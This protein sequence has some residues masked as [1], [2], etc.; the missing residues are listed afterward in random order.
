[1]KRITA[2]LIAAA[3]LLCSCAAPADTDITTGYTQAQ[4]T[5]A[6]YKSYSPIEA[7]DPC[8]VEPDERSVMSAND[9][10]QYKVLMDGMFSR[11][12]RI[13]L[14]LTGD[15]AQFLLDLLR[16]SPYYFFVDEAQVEGST[17]LLSYAYSADEQDEMRRF[18]DDELLAAANSD[19]CEGDSELDV[20]LKVY[21]AVASRLT[22]DDKREDNKELGSP[23]FDYPADEIYKAL[24]DGK[25]LCYGFA[26]VLR[27]ALLQRG[28]DCFCVYGE[29]RAHDQGHEWVIFRYDGEFF[30]CDPAW[31]RV[32]DEYPKLVNFGK[33]DAERTA[34]T[35]TPRPFDEYHY[36]KYGKVECTDKRFAALRGMVSFRY[37]S[38]HRYRVE[39]RNGY[40][41]VFDSVTFA[42]TDE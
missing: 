22:Y 31:D 30:N 13:E 12:E 8:A 32:A 21:G 20:I 16:Q 41:R 3:V 14:Y 2:L 18:I 38:G 7:I 17:V 11:K 9:V 6:E 29:C 33:T 10:E 5:E 24:K 39:D 19:A 42:L 37:L 4:P 36:A 26:Y 35:L 15:R 27:F 1:M 25:S 40:A 34:D 23:L 28:I